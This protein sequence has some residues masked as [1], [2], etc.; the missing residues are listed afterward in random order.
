MSLGDTILAD[1]AIEKVV[2]DAKYLGDVLASDALVFAHSLIGHISGA[3]PGIIADVSAAAVACF[4]DAVPSSFRG[5]VQA[6]V[7][8]IVTSAISPLDN[9]AANEVLSVLG[10]AVTRIEYWFS[11]FLPS[12]TVKAAMDSPQTAAVKAK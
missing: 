11:T 6:I 3:T 7:G 4:Y 1:P 12:E 8:G 5:T 10:L 2:T 9:A